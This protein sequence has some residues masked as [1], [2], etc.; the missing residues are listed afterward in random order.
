[1]GDYST[2]IT[3]Y[4]SLSDCL[5]DVSDKKLD[6]GKWETGPFD[7][8]SDTNTKQMQCKDKF[9]AAG[10]KGVLDYTPPSNNPFD[11]NSISAISTA[12]QCPYGNY[13]NEFNP[14]IQP[15]ALYNI[16][17]QASTDGVN[18]QSTV[19]TSGNP[20]YVHATVNVTQRSGAD[21]ELTAIWAQ[22]S[23]EAINDAGEA[24]NYQDPIW[25]AANEA[26]YSSCPAILDQNAPGQ[27]ISLTIDAS[28]D[29]WQ[30][31]TCVFTGILAGEVVCLSDAVTIIGGTNQ[32]DVVCFPLQSGDVYACIGDVEW[33]V[34]IQGDN[35]DINQGL[36]MATTRLELYWLYNSFP[37]VY[38]AGVYAFILRK[39][40]GLNQIFP[41]TQNAVIDTVVNTCFASLG[42]LYSPT[43][44]YTEGQSS[45]TFSIWRYLNET[46]GFVNCYDQ[47][48]ALQALLGSLGISSN[49]AMFFYCSFIP[50]S[51]FTN[52][53]IDL[54][55][56]GETNNP[57][58]AQNMYSDAP[59]VDPVADKAQRG[60]FTNHAF[61]LVNN[62]SVVVDATAGP[63]LTTH[64]AD[65]NTYVNNIMFDMEPTHYGVPQAWGVPSYN[66]GYYP[67]NGLQELNLSGWPGQPTSA[68]YLKA[69]INSTLVRQGPSPLL[70]EI[71]PMGDI[72]ER[73]VA[74]KKQERIISLPVKLQLKM[75][76]L[77]EGN[78]SK[79]SQPEQ[80]KLNHTV[81]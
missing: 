61:V 26:S 1:M 45:L 44:F 20:L 9:G 30:G 71:A 10:T 25:P 35:M 54:V 63:I 4:N 76:Q 27:G 36:A 62:S 75:L 50:G 49:Y 64:N 28:W 70:P 21:F 23:K 47:S 52:G 33:S 51:Y 80:K 69:V 8:S 29:F 59:Y 7:I 42:K 22:G 5:L 74:N 39:L 56:R 13:D 79:G 37:P 12:F 78:Q 3:F 58:F 43:P 32:V 38:S 34:S 6:H 24:T 73:Q 11:Y 67:K 65:D 77:G 19:P 60:A 18:W 40:F 16:S 41:G 2:Y 46:T 72:N 57:T 68:T 48:A 14:S 15:Y 31:I 53:Q 81:A 55:G 17:I 66:D